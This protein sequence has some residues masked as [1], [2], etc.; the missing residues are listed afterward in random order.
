MNLNLG[1]I[2]FSEGNGHPFSWSAI[3][4]GYNS[5]AMEQC[6]FPA[7]PRYLEKQEW[8]RDRIHGANVSMVWTQDLKLSESIAKAGLIPT[9]VEDLQDMVGRVDGVLLARDDS[10]NHALIAEPFLKAGLP[11]YIDKPIAL[12]KD[13]LE[14]LYRLEKREGQIF[15]CSALRYSRNLELTTEDEENI[16]QIES[17]EAVAPKSWDKY[18]IHIIEPVLKLIPPDDKIVSVEVVPGFEAKSAE[19]AQFMEVQWGSQVTTR[20][21]TTGKPDTS[22]SIKINGTEGEKTLE[23]GDPYM[24]FKS[25]LESFV[26]GIR[27]SSVESPKGFNMRVVDLIEKGRS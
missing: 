15:T 4:N 10:E 6:G 2:G 20:F 3:F 22:I 19:R 26:Q 8:P 18:V 21:L 5:D 1:L 27:L 24:S 17:I 23:F 16:G 12:S 14:N 13:E 9:V 11:I 25:A 7:I